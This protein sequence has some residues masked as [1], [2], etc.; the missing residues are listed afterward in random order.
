MPRERNESR[1]A[2]VP[3][4]WKES[5]KARMPRESLYIERAPRRVAGTRTGRGPART[6]RVVRRGPAVMPAVRLPHSRIV[7][8]AA[9]GRRPA[10]LPPPVICKFEFGDSAS[11]YFSSMELSFDYNDPCRDHVLAT[12]DPSEINIHVPRHTLDT[13]YTR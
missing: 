5:R 12:S 13:V 2:Q 7:G 10:F 9:S 4:E 3:R 8:P 6:G 11:S 1:K